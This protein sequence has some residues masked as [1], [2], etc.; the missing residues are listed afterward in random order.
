MNSNQLAEK[1]SLESEREKTISKMEE[2]LFKTLNLQST[3]TE[4]GIDETHF[5]IMAKKACNFKAI[6]GFVKLEPSD[7]EKILKDCL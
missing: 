2:F 1:I 5:E 7:V 4:I 3:L 6:N